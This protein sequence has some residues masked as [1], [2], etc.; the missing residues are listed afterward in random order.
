MQNGL[1]ASFGE[2]FNFALTLL[3]SWLLLADGG[4]CFYDDPEKSS[5]SKVE[6][7]GADCDPVY[8]VAH[9]SKYLF[10]ACRDKNIRKYAFEALLH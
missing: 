5:Q 6:F 2:A 10:T 8:D 7:T 3:Q 1:L 9:S 4:V